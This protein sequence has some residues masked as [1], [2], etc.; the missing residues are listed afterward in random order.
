[1]TNQN[2]LFDI[3]LDL[4]LGYFEV[5]TRGFW[6]LDDIAEFRSA[7][8]RTIHRIR[9]TGRMPVSLCD[10]SHAMVQSQEVV[11][12]F[13]QM[14]EAPAV[15]SGRVAVYTQGALTKFQATRANLD[16][17]EFRFFTCK[18]AARAWLLSPRD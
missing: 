2:P 5:V 7:L 16:H 4:G 1:M 17:G 3:T 9:A 14:M 13:M 12:A 6:S 10:Y 8:E 15:R 18:D 11:A